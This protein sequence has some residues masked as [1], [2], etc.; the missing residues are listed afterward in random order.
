MSIED[1]MDV[2]DI[3]RLQDQLMTFDPRDG[4][5]KPYPSHAKQFREWHGQDAWLFNPWTGKLRHYS[6]IGTD[7]TGVGIVNN[8]E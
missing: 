8:K 7:V 4:S 6:D 1:L 2:Q 3:E 5:Q